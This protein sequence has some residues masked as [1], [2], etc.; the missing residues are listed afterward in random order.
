D[1]LRA[2]LIGQRE[3]VAFDCPLEEAGEDVGPAGDIG[4]TYAERNEHTRDLFGDKIDE[5]ADTLSAGEAGDRLVDRCGF[6]LARLHG[7]E[8]ARAA[9][10]LFR[11]YIPAGDPE[12][13][14]R[15]RDGGI[16]FRPKW[17]HADDAALEIGGGLHAEPSE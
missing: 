4:S 3:I 14:Q 6:D 9:A 7:V 5:D 2:F 8:P 10:F 11:R 16:A 13:R 17:A 1:L 15:E 12:S